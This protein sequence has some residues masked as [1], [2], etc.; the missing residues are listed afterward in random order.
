[1]KLEP[2]KVIYELV[3]VEKDDDGNVIAEHPQPPATLYPPHFGEL[4]ERVEATM[5]A[6]VDGHRRA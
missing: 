3:V 5:A 2:F 1:M 6:G 4:A